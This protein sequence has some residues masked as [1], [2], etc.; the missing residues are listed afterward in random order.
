MRIG[1]KTE[2]RIGIGYQGSFSSVGI[3]WP[4]NF[5]DGRFRGCGGELARRIQWFAAAAQVI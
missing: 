5:V 4:R 2:H 3:N 1:S